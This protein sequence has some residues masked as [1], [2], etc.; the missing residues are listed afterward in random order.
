M[1]SVWDDC[2]VIV[3]YYES[4]FDITKLGILFLISN[5]FLRKCFTFVPKFKKQTSDYGCK[6]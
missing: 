2:F 3:I 5:D 4:G 1:F 6:T